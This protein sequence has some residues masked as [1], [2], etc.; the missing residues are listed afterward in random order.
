MRVAFAYSE[1]F[2]SQGVPNFII[3]EAEK[4]GIVFED[5][6]VSQG[7]NIEEIDVLYVLSHSEEENLEYFRSIGQLAVDHNVPVI[8]AVDG[9]EF[10]HAHTNMSDLS[11]LADAAPLLHVLTDSNFPKKSEKPVGFL[12]IPRKIPSQTKTARANYQPSTGPK[13]FEHVIAVAG[14]HGCGSSFVSWNL[15]AAMDAL[16]IEGNESS[17]LSKWISDACP[18]A[19]ALDNRSSK[20]SGVLADCPLSGHE[21]DLV[22]NSQ[23]TIVVDMGTRT[24]SDIWK[25]AKVKVQVLTPD[26]Q[27]TGF[28]D[29]A[30][31]ILN[32]VPEGFSVNP[33]KIFN[34][35]VDLVIPE[36]GRDVLYALYSK[37][38]WIIQ[39]PEEV[40]ARWRSLLGIKNTV[41]IQKELVQEW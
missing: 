29:D 3:V 15:A 39:Q 18:R 34:Q 11:T 21:L 36:M 33:D 35:R 27:F 13:P 2:E 22:A 26:P 6:S 16:L 8:W 5:W 7:P 14:P 4:S 41:E 20:S 19:E 9:D 17:T 38:P 24:D 25:K 30:T 32:R 40:K 28:I 23:R 12:K 1:F 37:E 31:K 10:E